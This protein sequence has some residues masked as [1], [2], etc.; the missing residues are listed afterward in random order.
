M[1]HFPKRCFAWLSVLSLC[2]AGSL[3]AR[4]VSAQHNTKRH[5]ILISIDGMT[6]IDYLH[7]D[8]G[9][10]IPNLQAL[11]ARGCRADG[12]TGIFPTVTYPSHTAM[13][14]G[15]PSSVHGIYTNTP[16]DPFGYENGGWYYYA[17]KIRSPTLWQV[18]REA[19]LK[20]AAVS[21]PVTVGAGIDYL[22]PEYRPV[23]TPEDVSLMSALSTPGLF[24]E[25]INVDSTDHPMTDAWRTKAS[26]RILDEHQPD[27]LALHLSDLDAAQHRYG[28]HT[29]EAHAAL[30]K[31]DAEIGEIHSAVAASGRAAGTA[32]VVVSDH[33]FLRDSLLVNPMVA[34]RDAGLIKTNPAGKL[35]DW[36]VF[37][38]NEGGSAFLEARNPNDTA[39]I[40]KATEI[41]RKLA[42]DPANG[43]AKI[44]APEDLKA[45]HSNPTAF[46]ALEAARGFAIGSELEGPIVTPSTTLGKHGYNPD[47][48]ELRPA[49]ILSGAGVYPCQLREGVRIVDVAPTVAALLGVSMH[50]VAG[51][52]VNTPTSH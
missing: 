43:I 51:R 52:N 11:E 42:A 18:L 28:P 41:M 33:G 45:M 48:P 3:A 1:S 24:R 23:R 50:G 15:E 25:M 40:A 31:I 47:I 14:T 30:E 34:L 2:I 19:D 49:M 8:G 20:T 38:N 37:I 29:P 46:L 22:L 4:T 12:M 16:L 6:A 39:S 32:W 35:V 9:L 17:D 5:V 36:K 44:D 27:L 26:V 21:W 13:I 10:K 7:P